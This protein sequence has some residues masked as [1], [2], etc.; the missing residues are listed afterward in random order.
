M[1]FLILYLP[2]FNLRRSKP[3]PRTHPALDAPAKDS[4][5]VEAAQGILPPHV[6][7]RAAQG[8]GL[9]QRRVHVAVRLVGVCG[10]FLGGGGVRVFLF[11]FFFG[12]GGW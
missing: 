12:G 9:G 4:H 3:H 2:N 5:A 6:L 7:V 1:V 11:C 10:F 8:L